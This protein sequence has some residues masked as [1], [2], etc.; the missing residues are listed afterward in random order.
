[1]NNKEYL[2]ILKEE[3]HSTVFAT[4]DE[5]GL[6]V[7]R[8]ID[9]MLVDDDCLYFITAKGKEFYRQ[10]MDKKYVAISGMTNGEGS[11]NKKAISIR[12]R[13]ENIGNRL[14]DEVFEQNIYE[15][16]LSIKRKQNG[17]RSI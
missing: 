3:I 6:P 5:N 7:T 13:I 1:M 4:V 16:N 14:L 10:L 2:R 11:L 15:R 9:I 12:G 8:V 17:V